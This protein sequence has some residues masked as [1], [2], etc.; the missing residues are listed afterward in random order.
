MNTGSY[1]LIFLH[2]SCQRFPL[3]ISVDFWPMPD[4]LRQTWVSNKYPGT[5]YFQS[6]Q[7]PYHDSE[8]RKI[9]NSFGDG[10]SELGQTFTLDV[11]R[12]V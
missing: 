12:N 1:E 11:G 2:K 7:H 6:D 3:T 8:V 10:M 5:K 9:D 4:Q